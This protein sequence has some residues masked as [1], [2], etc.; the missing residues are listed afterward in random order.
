A[1]GFRQMNTF[2]VEALVSHGYIVAAT[3]QPYTA[4]SVVF[5]DGHQA[6]GLSLDQMKPLIHQSYSPT[7]QAPTLNGRK[8]DKGI[9]PYLVQDVTFTLNQLA[10]LNQADPN[11]ILTGRLDLQHVGTFGVSLGGIVG[12]EACRL[13]PRLRACLVM[14]A[15]MPSDVVQAGLQQP[16]LWITR[17]AETM[18]L[19]R[20]RAGGWSEADI[21][22]H[23]TTMRAAFENLRGDGYF[24]QVPGMFHVNLTDIPYWS[25]LLSWLGVTGPIDGQRAHS[26]VN[27]YSLAFFDRHLQGRP[28]ALLDGPAEQYPEVRFETRRHLGNGL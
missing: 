1:I 19:E 8:L 28:A 15:P 7:E 3:D 13:E 20:R 5:P 23:Q 10:A 12:S 11:A 14:D 16:T 2:Q 4:A 22:E 25:P 24:V 27:A 9:V 18:R 26:I 17:D 6:T 21:R